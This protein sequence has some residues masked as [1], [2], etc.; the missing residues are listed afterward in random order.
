MDEITAIF[1]EDIQTE[2]EL[3]LFLKCL[4][5]EV[6]GSG[7]FSQQ[8]RMELVQLY[9]LAAS[10]FGG[11]LLAPHMVKIVGVLCDRLKGESDRKVVDAVADCLGVLCEEYCEE[12]M[13]FGDK[14]P[15]KPLM[16]ARDAMDV[17]VVPLFRLMR[18]PN[19]QAQLGGSAALIRVLESF[20]DASLLRQNTSKIATPLLKWFTQHR[21]F[22]G[23]VQLLQALGALFDRLT[24]L[25]KELKESSNNNNNN[26]DN[27]EDVIVKATVEACVLAMGETKNDAD[28]PIRR[29]GALLFR[30][31]MQYLAERPSSSLGAAALEPHLKRI[32]ELRF[33]KIDEVREAAKMA[34]QS[35]PA[36]L[37][38]Q[39]KQQEPKKKRDANASVATRTPVRARPLS[40][41]FASATVD[42]A[43]DIQIFVPRDFEAARIAEEQQRQKEMSAMV[44]EMQ[45]VRKQQEELLGAVTA[46]RK[47]V[48]S[49][50]RTLNGRVR[51]LEEQMQDL[52]E[53]IDDWREDQKQ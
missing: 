40:H 47:A 15:K 17:F 3:A 53:A 19:H 44:T 20:P 12:K 4:A 26:V 31:L 21:D 35:M 27:D 9:G 18:D 2:D 24:K 37:Q 6:L 22:G 5:R 23:R 38:E 29:E 1:A 48:E 42:E 43:S 49:G 30:L 34:V 11:A 51:A 52:T 10:V 39:V 33:D 14:T 13:P 32:G 46:L 45:M 36:P 28:W 41:S 7:N 8:A 50:M 25:S 16:T